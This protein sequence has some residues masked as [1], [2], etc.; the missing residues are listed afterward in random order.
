MGDIDLGKVVVAGGSGLVGR[1]LVAT[2]ARK[3]VRITILSRAPQAIEPPPGVEARGWDDLPRTLEGVDAVV[4]LCGEGIADA[5]WTEARQ[6]RVLDIRVGPTERL[7]QA[8]AAA[9]PR[10]RA[11]V[12]ASAVGYYGARDER[13]VDED[14]DPGRGFLSRVCVDWEAAAQAAADHGVRVAVLRLGVVLARDGGALPKMARAMRW[15]LGAKLGGGRQGLS[16]IHV[17]DLVRLVL[18]VAGNPAYRGP[19]NATAPALVS[20][21]AFTRTLCRRLHRLMLPAPGWATG[22]AVKMLLGQ[23][24]REMLLEGAY[25]LPGKAEE[26]GFTFRFPKLEDA[27]KDLL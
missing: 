19:V 14:A 17:D 16:W 21:E 1:R 7:V 15:C 2:L 22:A 10:P 8:M 26:L 23:M 3:G 4:N 9:A 6:R 25:V 24:G 27:L 13:P 12:N 11:L 20:N 18:E 5:R